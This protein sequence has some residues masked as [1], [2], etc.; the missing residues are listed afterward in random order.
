[1]W[2]DIQKTEKAKLK[3]RWTQ[4]NILPSKKNYTL[5]LGSK[6]KDLLC[7]RQKTSE[8]VNFVLPTSDDQLLFAALYSVLHDTA[9]FV[10]ELH[11]LVMLLFM[12]LKLLF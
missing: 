5:H 8:L 1:M 4:I 7:T 11:F 9:K 12:F 2:S 6:T 10:F 3:K